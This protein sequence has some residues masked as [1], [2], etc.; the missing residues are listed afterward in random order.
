MVTFTPAL[1]SAVEPNS[2]AFTP[3]VAI[4]LGWFE[5]KQ[6]DSGS[7]ERSGL[8]PLASGLWSVS[9]LE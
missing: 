2:G 7:L 8:G 6:L 4:C 9:S 1:F 5:C 3:P